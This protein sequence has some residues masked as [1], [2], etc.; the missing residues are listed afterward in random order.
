MTNDSLTISNI[1]LS[2]FV[3]IHIILEFVHYF[4]DFYTKRKDKDNALILKELREK[5][6]KLETIHDD[7]RSKNG[8]DNGHSDKGK[9]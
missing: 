4:Y 5:V 8:C 2:A 9:N 3:A 1:V 6:A 7:C